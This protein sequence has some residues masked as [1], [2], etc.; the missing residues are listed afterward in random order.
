MTWFGLCAAEDLRLR[1]NRG[2]AGPNPASPTFF[3]FFMKEKISELKGA[4]M[5][6][7]LLPNS[8]V[9][10]AIET[11]PWNK[12]EKTNSHKCAV[13]NVSI[14]KHFKGIKYSDIVLCSYQK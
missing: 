1:S 5:D 6:I 7:D 4:N 12:A 9:S 8:N 2:V 10:W 13:K 14:C 3:Y 11:C